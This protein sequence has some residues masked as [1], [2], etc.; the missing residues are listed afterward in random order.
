MRAF[1]LMNECLSLL[2]HHLLFV[3]YKLYLPQVLYYFMH[4]D[5]VDN[6]I[7]TM[8]GMHILKQFDRLAV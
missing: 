8:S 4:K 1:A 7:I 2:Y 3:M 6:I 5:N